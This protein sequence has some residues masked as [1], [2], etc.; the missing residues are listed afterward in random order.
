MADCND[1]FWMFWKRLA[2]SPAFSLHF[3]FSHC[4]LFSVFTVK[5]SVDLAKNKAWTGAC[6]DAH[7]HRV[8]AHLKRPGPACTLSFQ[9][10]TS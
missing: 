4:R 10:V 3:Y 2:Q 8:I 7:H 9:G 5:S 1:Y 6:I